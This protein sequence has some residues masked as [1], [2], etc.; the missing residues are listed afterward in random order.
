MNTQQ[1]QKAIE[2]LD[3][4]REKKR[5]QRYAMMY[6][7]GAYTK[8]HCDGV[9]LPYRVLLDLEKAEHEKIFKE[10]PPNPY[11]PA[12]AVTKATERSK[13]TYTGNVN[14]QLNENGLP[15][16]KSD[17][18][19]KREYEE[20]ERR[21]ESEKMPSDKWGYYYARFLLP[22]NIELFTDFDFWGETPKDGEA[23]KVV[24]RMKDACLE[25]W[26]DCKKN[27]EKYNLEPI[28]KLEEHKIIYNVDYN[29]I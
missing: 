23:R 25:V 24:D 5:K 19:Y 27:P 14:L 15:N 18:N 13:P 7:L 28:P 21:K 6:H 1:Q 11:Y 3:R 12:P 4:Q 2:A 10:V 9:M 8:L 20:Y 16:F 17:L 22:Y 26:R 29:Y